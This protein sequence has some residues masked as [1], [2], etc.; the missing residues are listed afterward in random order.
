MTKG[1]TSS[2]WSR[3]SRSNTGSIGRTCVAAGAMLWLVRPLGFRLD[4]RYL[5]RAGLDYWPHLNYRV[6]NGLDEVVAALGRD[7]LWSFSTKAKRVYTD[8][9][10][11]PGDALVLAPRAAAFRCD[12]WKNAPTEPSASRS[13]LRPAA[14]TWL[15]PWPL[16]CSKHCGSSQSLSRRAPKE[17]HNIAWSVSPRMA[18]PSRI[19]GLLAQRRPKVGR[20]PT[21]GRRLGRGVRSSSC[22]GAHAPGYIMPPP[23]GG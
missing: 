13:A 21:F 16:G 17:R 22:P 11:Q 6:V 7:R 23:F 19:F 2:S 12:G 8:A 20:R 14:S 1:C 10:Y 3:R 4:D 15:T 5:R 9:R 18:K